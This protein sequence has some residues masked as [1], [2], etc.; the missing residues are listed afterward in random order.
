MK[1]VEALRSCDRSVVLSVFDKDYR[2][3]YSSFIDNLLKLDVLSDKDHP[4]MY[5]LI[6]KEISIDLDTGDTSN[7][8]LAVTGIDYDS[9]N[10]SN[11]GRWSLMFTNH[12][13]WLGYRISQKSISEFGIDACVA[14]C[15]SEMT[16]FGFSQDDM[17]KEHDEVLKRSEEVTN[18]TA[19]LHPLSDLFKELNIDPSECIMSPEEE[20]IFDK[21]H[22]IN[23]N[24]FLSMI[25]HI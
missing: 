20:A 10:L 19:N 16:F 1:L 12:Q 6:H 3:D 17:D 15:L 21:E 14:A 5:L 23:Q 18:G 24:N 13:V 25:D 8:D 9:N 22:E 4:N 2:E 11:Y 7:Y